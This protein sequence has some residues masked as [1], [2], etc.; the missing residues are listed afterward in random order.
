MTDR[1]LSNVRDL[2]VMP[3]VAAKILAFKEHEFDLSF[4]QLQDIIKVDIGLTTKILKIANSALYARQR[5][6][7]DLQTAIT[8]LGFKNIKTLILLVTAST[9]FAKIR[10]T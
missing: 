4:R 2:P 10:K 6:I 1:Y 5:E 3:D 9:F 7:K 8:L